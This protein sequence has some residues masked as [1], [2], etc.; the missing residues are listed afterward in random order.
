MLRKRCPDVFLLFNAIGFYGAS[1]HVNIGIIL[2]VKLW[3]VFW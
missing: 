1:L 3:V 2:T